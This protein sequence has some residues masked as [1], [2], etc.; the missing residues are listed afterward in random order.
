MRS[1]TVNDG[2]TRNVCLW[3]SR[4]AY[5]NLYNPCYLQRTNS[6]RLAGLKT[7]DRR[8]AQYDDS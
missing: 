7:I 3:L 4:V 1:D 8:D 6:N 2:L 5:L